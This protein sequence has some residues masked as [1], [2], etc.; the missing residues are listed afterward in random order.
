M[1]APIT[2]DPFVFTE[3]A[4]SP[5]TAQ[6]N[7]EVEKVLS[8][9]ER[10]YDVGAAETR[11][12]RRNG[13][14]VLAM[15]PPS[16]I[17]EWRTASAGGAETPVRVFTPDAMRGIYL[18]I[19]GG[20]HT[21]GGADMQDQTLAELAKSLS[22]AVVSV[23]YRL[24]PEHPYPAGPDDCE[25]AARW[26]VEN[27]KAEFGTDKIVIGGESA[28]AHL[29]VVTLLRMRDR[30]GFTGFAGANLVYGVFDMSMTPSNRHWGDRLLVL[31]RRT[32]DWFCDNFLPPDQFDTETRRAPD[33]SP[34][35]ADLTQLPPALFTIGTLDP[36]L[37]DSLFMSQRWLQ[38]GADAELA[39]YPGGIHA[40]DA[41][42][43][44]IA[45]M[46]RGRM[47]DFI[48]ARIS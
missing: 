2:I 24:A 14:G 34:L 18:H 45:R 48:S 11:D 16:E 46:A 6:M 44:A 19:H 25:T 21:I 32:I 33:I 1:S 23:E 42:P 26:L 29:S 36:L 31:N 7:A 12:A 38:S 35:Y 3:A 5:E 37:D 4:I 8:T 13:E 27:A 28:G 9:M 40:F 20:G 41:F 47:A 43:I 15:Q 39:I 30:H 22:V 17:A 10:I